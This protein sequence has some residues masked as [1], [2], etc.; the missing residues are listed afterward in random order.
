MFFGHDP[1]TTSRTKSEMGVEEIQQEKATT[2]I[3]E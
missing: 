3:A 1:E 2:T